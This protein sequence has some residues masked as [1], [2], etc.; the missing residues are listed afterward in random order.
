MGIVGWPDFGWYGD[1]DPRDFEY[2]LAGSG[3]GAWWAAGW[4][5]D[6][7]G[8]VALA[9]RPGPRPRRGG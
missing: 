9:V 8:R 2:A 4:S 5:V 7:V 6:G 3:T 1:C